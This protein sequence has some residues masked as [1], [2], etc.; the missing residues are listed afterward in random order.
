MKLMDVARIDK[1]EKKR[2]MASS[3]TRREQAVPD[4][5]PTSE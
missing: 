3:I 1:R 4:Y 5:S 2:F